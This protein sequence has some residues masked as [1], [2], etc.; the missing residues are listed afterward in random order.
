MKFIKLLILVFLPFLVNAQTYEKFAAYGT[1]SS[2]TLASGNTWNF[3]ITG[4]TGNA[5]PYGSPAFARGDAQVG[6][7]IFIGCNQWT[8][9]TITSTAP[10]LVG[11]MTKTDGTTPNPTNGQV[12]AIFREFTAPN[13]LIS[14]TLPP[15]GD[16]NGGAVAGISI[17]LA[18]C[19]KSHYSVKDSISLASAINKATDVYTYLGSTGV[20]PA[21]NPPTISQYLARNTAG[22]LYKYNTL[23]STWEL[24]G[25]SIAT[26]DSTNISLQKTGAGIYKATIIPHTIDS[27]TVSTIAP[28]QISNKDSLHSMNYRFD[29]TSISNGTNLAAKSFEITTNPIGKI[30]ASANAGAVRY[31]IDMVTG[32]PVSNGLSKNIATNEMKL[33]GALNEATTII[34]D[35]SNTFAVQGLQIGNT[36]DS[37]VTVNSTGALRK[38]PLDSIAKKEIVSQLVAP[39]GTD[40]LKVWNNGIEAKVYENG[41]WRAIVDIDTLT[42]ISDIQ[43]YK[44]S[45]RFIEIT[46][47]YGKGRFRKIDNYTDATKTLDFSLS[48]LSDSDPNDRVVT[49]TGLTS[50]LAGAYIFGAGIAKGTYIS[51]VLSSTTVSV[52]QPT[53]ITT[54]SLAV[55]L[56]KI[57][58]FYRI[59]TVNNIVYERVN[60]YNDINVEFFGGKGDWS[61]NTINEVVYSSFQGTDNTLPFFRALRYSCEGEGVFG[62]KIKLRKGRYGVSGTINITKDNTTISGE[63]DAAS[64]IVFTESNSAITTTYFN[65]TSLKRIYSLF[66][67]DL[68]FAGYNRAQNAI[69]AQGCNQSDFQN[70]HF[71]GFA[72]YAIKLEDFSSSKIQK[73]SIAGYST[74]STA[75]GVK[76]LNTSTLAFVSK[77]YYNL[78]VGDYYENS[79]NI[80][81]Y[82]NRFEAVKYGA[83]IENTHSLGNNIGNIIYN[84]SSF[85]STGTDKRILKIDNQNATDVFRAIGIEFNHLR[86]N[87]TSLVYAIEVTGTFNASSNIILNV[88]NVYDNT[89]ITGS[90]LYSAWQK[91]K[92]YTDRGNAPY[93]ITGGALDGYYYN[94]VLMT[95]ASPYGVYVAPK[96]TRAYNTTNNLSYIKVTDESSSIGWNIVA[97]QNGATGDPVFTFTRGYS[98]HAA[99]YADAS[100]LTS[101]Y[102]YVGNDIYIKKVASDTAKSLSNVILQNRVTGI[103]GTT[104]TFTGT[105][106]PS[107]ADAS[108]IKIYK[109]G[110]FQEVGTGNDY[111]ISATTPITLTVSVAAILTDKYILRIE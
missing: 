82:D 80:S 107:G 30:T 31:E 111:T 72:D 93:T 85:N 21:T 78:N 79:A 66:L 96:G 92:L 1:T 64:E 14:Y 68:R 8:I 50:D 43:N 53:G 108:H 34:T 36:T 56:S 110:V 109:N 90:F 74:S 24:I 45:K 95:T 40:T 71:F 77:E 32:T 76:I 39:L 7:K 5:R 22:E 2:L 105:N 11:T 3:T 104:V 48:N 44:G 17:S 19:I 60:E 70:L 61:A 83:F 89:A 35:A 49:G 73:L 86:L 29:G 97:E 51:K 23:I 28:W 106:L 69:V 25:G 37:I 84:N 81:N 58:T 20:L 54:S 18:A 59:K 94:G 26:G 98:N 41:Q 101:S 15:T 10:N 57:D 6:D 102:Y 16:G 52:N 62:R 9:T 99:A 27:N 46:D 88:R 67:K 100:L 38:M 4:F 12:V 63:G 65:A 13:G 91:I 103:T 33:G 42:N 55:T 47:Q 87:T 75:K